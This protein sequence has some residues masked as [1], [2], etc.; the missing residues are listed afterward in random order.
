MRQ[1]QTL[2]C[3]GSS[4]TRNSGPAARGLL[5]QQD[6]GPACA[7]LSSPRPS[8][9]PVG[10][11]RLSTAYH[12]A[13][14]PH[15]QHPPCL[16][17]PHSPTHTTH[18]A[19]CWPLFTAR[20]S[21]GWSCRTAGMSWRRRSPPARPPRSR[22]TTCAASHPRVSVC[23][24]LGLPVVVRCGSRSPS[25][26]CQGCCWSQ[27]RTALP[28]ACSRQGEGGQLPWHRPPRLAQQDRARAAGRRA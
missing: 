10:C 18:L 12:E 28:A 25:P 13:E 24:L 4:Y 21:V 5:G 9:H 16:P 2:W 1:S 19:G 14:Q 8:P 6:P 20:P 7:L 27:V 22:Q 17:L 23:L 15:H 11:W 26:W 3:S